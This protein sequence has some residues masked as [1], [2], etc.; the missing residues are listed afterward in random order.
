VLGVAL[1]KQED[2]KV[3]EEAIA[4][5]NRAIELGGGRVAKVYYN[6]GYTLIKAGRDAE[7]VEALKK[8]LEQ[9]PS[10]I[11]RSAVEAV[12]ANPK[13]SKEKFALSFKVTSYKGEELSLDKFKGKVVL[14]DFWATWCGPCREEMPEVKKMWKKYSGDNFVMIGIS[15]DHNKAAFERYIEQ[16]EITWPQ[17]IDGQERNNNVSRLYNVPSIPYTVLIDQY[18]IIRAVGLRGGSLSNKISELLKSLQKQ[19]GEGS[20]KSQ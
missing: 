16:E 13:L 3:L 8:Y 12:I 18:G 14:L 19:E 5:F 2:K 10:A 1:F 9:N 15:L 7:G 20:P 4:A 11:D 6:L 17:Y